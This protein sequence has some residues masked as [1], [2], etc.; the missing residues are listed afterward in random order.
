MRN[1]GSSVGTSMVTTIIA[2]R[3]QYHQTILIGQTTPG[4]PVFSNAVTRL[5]DHLTQSG[6][7]P[8][9]AQVRAHAELYRSAQNQAAAL[10]YIDVFWILGITAAVMFCLSFVLKK[11]DPGQRAEGAAG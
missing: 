7:S 2:R 11:N 9:D 6:L 1:M 4:N 8:D 10:A 5:A 3:S